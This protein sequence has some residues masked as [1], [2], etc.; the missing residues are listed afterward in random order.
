MCDFSEYF[1]QTLENLLTDLQ[2]ISNLYEHETMEESGLVGKIYE[3]HYH[4][5]HKKGYNLRLF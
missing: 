5:F 2:I 1:I 3:D 4:I